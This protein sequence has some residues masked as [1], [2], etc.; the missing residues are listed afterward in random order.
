M[1]TLSKSELENMKRQA[2]L[3]LQ[4]PENFKNTFD[5]LIKFGTNSDESFFHY[6]FNLDC[7]CSQ[8][9]YIE[10]TQLESYETGLVET[11][12]TRDEFEDHYDL[13][14]YFDYVQEKFA[15][16]LNPSLVKDI[17]LAVLIEKLRNSLSIGE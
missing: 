16:V 8:Q 7:F 11:N 12:L 5:F 13:C 14:E 6:C 2:E 1:E 15:P 9:K 17:V 4:D 3:L 10:E